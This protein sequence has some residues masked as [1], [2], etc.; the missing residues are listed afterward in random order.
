M[1]GSYTE[2]EFEALYELGGQRCFCCG[3][4]F[5]LEEL[6]E[7]HIEPIGLGV[8]NRIDNIQLLCGSCNS[9]KGRQTIDYRPKE[10]LEGL[11]RREV[12]AS[13]HSELPG[14]DAPKLPQ[15]A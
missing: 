1:V 9:K 13:G 3:E 15:S 5:P 6:T 14:G 11:R 8:S 7:D 2:E 4:S 12:R 10:V